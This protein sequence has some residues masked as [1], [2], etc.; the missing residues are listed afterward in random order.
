VLPA[1]LPKIF[2]GLRLSLSIAVIL[3]VI[4][5]MVGV[6][7]GIGYQLIYAQSQFDITILWAWMVLLGILGYGLNLA[8]LAVERRALRWQPTRAQLARG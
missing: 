1:A 2:A 5:E 6:T 3:M 8:L 4:S 7:N